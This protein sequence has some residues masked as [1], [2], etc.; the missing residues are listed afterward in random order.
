MEILLLA[1]GAFWAYQKFPFAT[2]LA[3]AVAPESESADYADNVL[4]PVPTQDYAPGD[5][6]SSGEVNG[7]RVSTYFPDDKFYNYHPRAQ[8]PVAFQ[9]LNDQRPLPTNP[10][11]QAMM[12]DIRTP[13]KH[14]KSNNTSSSFRPSWLRNTQDVSSQKRLERE[15]T[16]EDSHPPGHQDNM[17]AF[18]HAYRAQSTASINAFGHGG[19]P[20]ERQFVAPD[21]LDPVAARRQMTE[22]FHRYTLDH[23]M[24]TSLKDDGRARGSAVGQGSR[25]VSTRQEGWELNPD[26]GMQMHANSGM[27]PAK[28]AGMRLGGVGV[29]LSSFVGAQPVEPLESMRGNNEVNPSTGRKSVVNYLP[30]RPRDDP[31]DKRFVYEQVDT[32]AGIGAAHGS[33]ISSNRGFRG[34]EHNVV[35]HVAGVDSHAARRNVAMHDRVIQKSMGDAADKVDYKFS[36]DIK[37]LF[38]VSATAAGL[39][40]QDSKLVASD[41]VRGTVVD[42]VGDDAVQRIVVDTSDGNERIETRLEKK[43][44]FSD[45]ERKDFTHHASA[46]KRRDANFAPQAKNAAKFQGVTTFKTDAANNDKRITT[47]NMNTNKG[48]MT[49]V[50]APTGSNLAG[51]TVHIKKGDAVTKKSAIGDGILYENDQILEQAA[52][53]QQPLK[54][55]K[56]A[57]PDYAQSKINASRD[58]GEFRKR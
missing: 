8:E 57:I 44:L 14:V 30:V 15:Q 33:A 53:I 26:R 24:T 25:G 10:V 17:N 12:E 46:S 23:D 47:S 7:R 48:L 51:R 3:V 21:G 1:S 9:R 54:A 4:A 34:A 52:I 37:T 27:K 56:G 5:M 16:W 28:S 18:Q 38:D 36:F 40:N 20:E 11:Q 39:K 45:K 31:L 32:S 41:D 13:I 58:A 29:P 22:R 42:M 2:S 19:V 50:A 6:D 43:I 49:R 35:D 55:P